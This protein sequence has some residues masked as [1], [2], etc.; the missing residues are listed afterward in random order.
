ME[1][2][3]LSEINHKI[4]EIKKRILLA[5]EANKKRSSFHST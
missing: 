5:G 1:N 2:D 3:K 4:A